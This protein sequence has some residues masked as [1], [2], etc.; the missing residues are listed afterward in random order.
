MGGRYTTSK[1]IAAIAG[2]RSAAVR[3][4]PL[5]GASPGSTT[6][7]SDRGNISYQEPKSARLRSISSGSGLA[8]VTSSRSG[9]FRRAASTSGSSAAAYR[10]STSRSSSRMTSAAASTASRPS[11]L[12]SLAAARV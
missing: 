9:F 1:P 2:S 3:N 7:P 5:T 12:G 4:V 6:A 10:T 11:R 8:A